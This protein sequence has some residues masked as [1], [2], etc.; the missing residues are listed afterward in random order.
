[1]T[2][3]NNQIKVYCFN[4]YDVMVAD[5]YPENPFRRIWAPMPSQHGGEPQLAPMIMPM[6]LI[7]PVEGTVEIPDNYNIAYKIENEELVE[8]MGQSLE[9]QASKGPRIVAPSQDEL[10]E[11]LRDKNIK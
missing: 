9:P 11:V 4:S 10:A 6:D 2:K 1:M 5:K 8:S 3:T 7:Q